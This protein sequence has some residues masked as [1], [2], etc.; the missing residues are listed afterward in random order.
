MV[1]A[2]ITRSTSI[3]LA[4]FYISLFLLSFLG[5]NAVGYNMVA[6]YLYERLDSNV[7]ERFR[8]I[9]AAY[10]KNGIDGA[11]AMIRSHGA[12]IRGQETLYVLRDA[13]NAVLAGNVDMAEVSPGFSTR[14]PT[15]H[16]RTLTNYR[17]YRKNL[18]QYDLTVGVSYDDTNRLRWIAL[19]SFGWAT[20]I[21][22]AVGLGGGAVL[23]FRTRR[24]IARLSQAMQAVGAG[25]LATACRFRRVA[26]TSMH[27]PRRSTTRSD[28]CRRVS[29]P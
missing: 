12:A 10:D 26:T 11:A 3:R 24:R 21:V 5:A 17:L 20:A 14:A 4:A 23:A 27:W 1:N 6:A 16:D 2:S 19:V 28:N 9:A 22:L 15:S 13:G 25:E 7:M 8:E 29:R 18:D